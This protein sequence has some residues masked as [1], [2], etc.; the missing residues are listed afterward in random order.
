MCFDAHAIIEKQFWTFT[1]PK[2]K[3]RDDIYNLQRKI[4]KKF[5]LVCDVNLKTFAPACIVFP[6][7]LTPEVQ[8]RTVHPN[9]I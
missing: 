5:F 1:D 9:D 4:K 8:R 7:S 6:N 3:I 2:L